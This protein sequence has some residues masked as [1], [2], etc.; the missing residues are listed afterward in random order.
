MILVLWEPEPDARAAKAVGASCFQVPTVEAGGH[1]D[2]DYSLGVLSRAVRARPSVYS[3][4][5]WR[6]GSHSLV[7]RVRAGRA[8]TSNLITRLRTSKSAARRSTIRR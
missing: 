1:P 5:S 4:V 3:H 8:S 2:P 6:E 7:I